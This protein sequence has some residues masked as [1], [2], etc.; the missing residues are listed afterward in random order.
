MVKHHLPVKF[1]LL[2]FVC[3]LVS[4]S[5]HLSVL[6]S[7]GLPLFGH[8][9]VCSYI[10]NA[11]L[12]AS[13]LMLLYTFRQKVKDQIGFLFMGGSLAKYIVFLLLFYPSYKRDREIQT[14]E[15]AAF[16]VPYGIALFLETY[17]VIQLLKTL[18]EPNTK[19]PSQSS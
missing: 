1:L 11:L 14:L 4:F 19:S 6:S 16:F 8:L 18:E 12:A 5:V 10:V 9:I 13:I 3:L 2:L 7:K 15:F 17:F